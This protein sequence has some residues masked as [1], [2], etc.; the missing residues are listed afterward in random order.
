MDDQGAR[1]ASTSGNP[2]SILLAC[3]AAYVAVAACFGQVLDPSARSP[4]HVAQL[5]L[6]AAAG[7]LYVL[8]AS[9]TSQSEERYAVV[10]PAIGGAVTVLW[11]GVVCCT[12]LRRF[13]VLGHLILNALWLFFGVFLLIRLGGK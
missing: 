9:L 5:T 1:Q 3:L 7:P 8:T 13:S 12:P 4:K 6:G 10:G 11:L 2:F